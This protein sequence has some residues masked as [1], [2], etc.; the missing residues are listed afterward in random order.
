MRAI[1]KRLRERIKALEKELEEVK[2]D[3]QK[4]RDHFGERF[5]W[6]IKLLGEQ[7]SPNLSWLIES[8]AK[9]M[10]YAERWWW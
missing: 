1:E 7:K 2:R 3:R 4:F 10:A 6:F 5:K 8:D 9:F